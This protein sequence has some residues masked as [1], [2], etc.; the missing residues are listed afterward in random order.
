MPVKE[1]S[2]HTDPNSAATAREV[3]LRDGAKRTFG[4]YAAL[5]IATWGVGYFPIAPGTWGS[6]VGVGIFLLLQQ[7]RIKLKTG[8]AGAVAIGM[9]ALWVAIY[10]VVILVISLAGV[11]AATRVEAMSG[12]KDPGIVVADE[13]AGQLIT[14]LVVPIFGAGIPW[15]MIFTGFMLFRLFDIW[16][17]YPIRRLE[18]LESGLGVMADD[19]L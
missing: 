16:K 4:D 13:V 1:S 18:G 5:A 9:D 12:R 10:L 11:W 15:L 8:S 6:L 14:L 3:V 7:L 17:P 19:I 2:D